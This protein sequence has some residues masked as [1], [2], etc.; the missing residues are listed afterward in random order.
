MTISPERLAAYADG[1]LSDVDRREIE[2]AI[3]ADPELARQV[4]AHRALRSRLSAHFAPILSAPLPERLVAPLG[5]G[6][7]R[8]IDLAAAREHRDR[9]RRIPRWTWIAGPALAA[10]LVLAIVRPGGDGSDITV[11]DG[12]RY[13]AGSLA[14]ALDEQLSANQPG[15]APTRILLSFK[16]PGGSYCRGFSGEERAGIA[17]R[18]AQGWQVRKLVGAS[19]A[20]RGEYGQAGGEQAALLAAAQDMAADGALDAAQEQSA[21]ARG[22]R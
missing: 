13:A 9:R 7:E 12:R 22:W 6:D 17:C 1:E 14:Q 11:I 3:A 4:A 10:S 19:G 15:T 16:D 18:D 20:A 21:R 5:L 8:V 2:I